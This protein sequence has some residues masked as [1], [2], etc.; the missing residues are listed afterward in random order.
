MAVSI[1]T[2]IENSTDISLSVEF[3][4]E[5]H[6]TWVSERRARRYLVRNAL[7]TGI[8][9][10]EDGLVETILSWED[11]KDKV[12]SLVDLISKRVGLETNS[13]RNSGWG[14]VYLT[15]RQVDQT[16]R[17]EHYKGL[18][19]FLGFINAVENSVNEQG[20]PSYPALRAINA[21]ARSGRGH[22]SPATGRFVHEYGAVT[23]RMNRGGKSPGALERKVWAVKE[24]ALTKHGKRISFEMALE[25]ISVTGLRTSK[26]ATVAVAQCYGYS[27]R[28]FRE[29]REIVTSLI[30]GGA[31]APTKGMRYY[32]SHN[33]VVPSEI[34]TT[35]EGYKTLRKRGWGWSILCHGLS[36]WQVSEIAS[37]S[38][39]RVIEIGNGHGYYLS[40]GRVVEQL[41]LE[42]ISELPDN[43][44]FSTA[45][46]AV[47]K[48]G[49]RGLSPRI[50]QAL[51]QEEITTLPDTETLDGVVSIQ[52]SKTKRLNDVV[53]YQV[54]GN[55]GKCWVF[56]HPTLGSYHANWRDDF[57]RAFTY[58]QQA[59]GKRGRDNVST[60]NIEE[61][62][63][64]T[65][66]CHLVYL[67][68]SRAVGNC[69]IGTRQWI[70]NQ[71]LEGET[72]ISLEKL[73]ELAK[74]NT[75]AM[76]VVKGVVGQI[77][78]P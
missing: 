65:S 60:S 55:H 69:S 48:F 62:L 66:L 26:A 23:H 11:G 29:A 37:I 34:G 63:G 70:K 45:N 50:L 8:L 52:V 75:L 40:D 32:V 38:E 25:A 36:P 76:N 35:W 1:N 73:Y 58:A 20:R 33:E 64:D 57:K 22:N 18:A 17:V 51:Y 54:I 14:W 5:T 71:G 27:P 59:F 43:G 3:G 56:K 47:E 41:S 68:D 10:R 53:F 6:L 74:G 9:D 77:L 13:L 28:S 21:R 46:F 31:P 7:D 67:D 49:V 72:L 24:A 61:V 16:E 30:L 39:T 19:Q 12:D 2:L 15:E 78:H 4:S 44:N 42:E